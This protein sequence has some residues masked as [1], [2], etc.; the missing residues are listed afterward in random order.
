MT[1]DESVPNSKE[2]IAETLQSEGLTIHYN[3]HLEFS[4]E[5]NLRNVSPK[6]KP[7]V[8]TVLKT[9][10]SY[11]NKPLVYDR[12]GDNNEAREVWRRKMEDKYGSKFTDIYNQGRFRRLN[13]SLPLTAI[14]T[15]M[16]VFELDAGI[17]KEEF[18][19]IKSKVKP[20]KATED[21]EGFEPYAHLTLKEKERMVA[22]IDQ[23]A[24][25]VLTHFVPE[26]RELKST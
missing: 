25:K 21:Q 23:L 24:L 2:S 7:G 15:L 11:L 20:R 3:D 9:L 18:E 1:E 5:I 13:L 8:V 10:V 19:E 16:V 12:F 6:D 4:G 14:E 17:K 22:K 26:L